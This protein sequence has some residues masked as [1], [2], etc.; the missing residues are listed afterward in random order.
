MP[1]VT[2]KA[3]IPPYASGFKRGVNDA[4]TRY[5]LSNFMTEGGLDLTRRGSIKAIL[6]VTVQTRLR[7]LE[8]TRTKEP[9]NVHPA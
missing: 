4:K 9:L 3:T 8:V 6:M 7:D 2:V 1:T 5:G